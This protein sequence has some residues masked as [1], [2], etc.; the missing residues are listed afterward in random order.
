MGDRGVKN[1]FLGGGK[2]YLAGRRKGGG[3]C[4][5]SEGPADGFFC[6]E[7]VSGYG[8]YATNPKELPG[9]PPLHSPTSTINIFTN[10]PPYHSHAYFIPFT[11]LE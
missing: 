1:V 6:G 4:E 7:V 2:W 10:L 11:A 5:G 3:R 8:G 9:K